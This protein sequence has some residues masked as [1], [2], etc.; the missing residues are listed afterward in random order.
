[1]SLFG[2][3]F[4]G[5]TGMTAQ[6]QALGTISENITNVNTVGYKAGST[7]FA[8]LVGDSSN[9]ASVGGV[10][11]IKTKSVNSQGILQNTA[12]A[13]DIAI[14][15]SGFFVANDSVIA[16]EPEGNTIF[17]RAGHF[18]MDEEKRLVNASGHFL[19]GYKLNTGGDY[20]DADN[21]VIVPDRTTALD[22][23]PVD[24]SEFAFVSKATENVGIQASFPADMIVA[25]TFR[26]TTNIV[27]GLSI[28]HALNFDYT[29]SDHVALKGTFNDT[30]GATLSFANISTPAASAITA[31]TFEP[32]TE[33][34][35]DLAATSVAA[36]V[37]TWTGT[38]TS[39]NGTIAD[40]TFTLTFENGLMTSDAVHQID[41][42]W[43]AALGAKDTIFALDFSAF[44]FSVGGAASKDATTPV[45]LNQG[46]TFMKIDVSTSDTD[47]AFISGDGTFA[48]F[49]DTGKLFDPSSLD[50]VIDWNDGATAAADSS[51]TFDLGKIGTTSG[52]SMVGDIFRA[53][54]PS[55]DGIEAGDFKDVAIDN[56]FVFA[57]FTNGRSI[58]VFQLPIAT[59]N[60]PNGLKETSGNAYQG[61]LESGDFLLRDAGKGG[62]GT[63][64]S[65]RLE[66]STVDIT[67]EF[68]NMIITQRAFSSASTVIKTA[69]E[70]LQELV[71]LKR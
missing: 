54:A 50:M 66:N 7:Q 15:G 47:D 63:I 6:S 24:L 48:Q 30:V 69:D 10:T 9:P 27:D 58:A 14:S 71:Q 56:G 51:I 28:G 43:D 16:G 8:T 4:S 40:N 20:V 13:T 39:A 32:S 68:A 44:G 33:I 21:N 61:T 62:A 1:M 17:T 35:V 11:Q 55:Q 64:A 22:L 18:S 34:S 42:A 53:G 26:T 25:D 46:N 67:R 12:N 37:T 5:V 57:N 29:K 31:G 65:Q 38:V 52:L 3:L 60:N 59:F 70:M 23:R 49:T 41:V 19:M 45:A 36:G 2:S